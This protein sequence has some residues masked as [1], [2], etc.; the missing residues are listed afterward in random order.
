MSDHPVT[1]ALPDLGEYR[2]AVTRGA[3]GDVLVTGLPT[4]EVDEPVHHLIATEGVVFALVLVVAALIGL[5]V[6]RRG[7]G[8]LSRIA[9]AARGVSQLPLTSGSVILPDPV[10][11]PRPGTEVGDVITAFNRMLEHVQGALEQRHTDEEKLRHFVADASH[12]LRTPVAVIASYAEYAQRERTDDPAAVDHALARIRAESARMAHL[13]DDLLLLARLDLGRALARQPVD[14]TRLVLDAVADAARL[15]PSHHW[16]LDLPEQP[17]TVCGDEHALHQAIANLLGN[18]RAHTPPG[19][20]VQVT[21][22]DRGG[23]VRVAVHDDGPG[24]AVDLLP[25]VFERFTRAEQSRAR[26]QGT[27]LG[28]AIADGIVD[29]HLGDITVIS[30]PGDTTFTIDLPSLTSSATL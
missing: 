19:T 25:F 17:A 1:V 20:A 29:A 6:I 15:S 3:D 2:V 27:G 13:V 22:S 24:I 4:R 28:L 30:E 21:V 8:P 11:N 23:R 12:E 9:V 26:R 5:G 18:A 10:G 16:Q 7:L 14:I